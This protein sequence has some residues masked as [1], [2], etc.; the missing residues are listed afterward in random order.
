MLGHVISS[1]KT[2]NAQAIHVVIGHGAEQVKA[3][4]TDDVNWA[5]QDQQ[6]GTGHAVAQ[7]LPLLQPDSTVLIAY[8]D[9]P[10]VQAQTLQK[11]LDLRLL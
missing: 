1:A 5:I 7:A 4:I 9:V 11:L 6:L 2:I 8:G 3:S 10:L